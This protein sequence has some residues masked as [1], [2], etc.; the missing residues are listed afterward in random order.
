[1]QE[2]LRDKSLNVLEHLWIDLKIPV[3]QRSPYNLTEIENICR[4][5]WEKLPKNRCAKLVASY[6]RRLEA[7]HCQVSDL[8]PIGFLIVVG[9]QSYQRGRM[10]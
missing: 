9:D 5:E 2:Y 7:P 6:T 1:M 4:E 3:K 10:C 8:L